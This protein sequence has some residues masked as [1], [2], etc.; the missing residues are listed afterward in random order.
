MMKYLEYEV[1]T[2]RILSEVTSTAE[3]EPHDGIQYLP[4]DDKFSV[5]TITH[6]ITGGA[7]KKNV[8]TNAER[9]ERERLKREHQSAARL[10]VK[11]MTFELSVAILANDMEAVKELQKEYAGM[12]A[13]L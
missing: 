10:R 7:I 5:D 2:G 9:L 8:E 13:V 6:I 12:R 1:E 3:P 4:V 11:A